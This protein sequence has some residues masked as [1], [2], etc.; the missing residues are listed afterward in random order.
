M[1]VVHGDVESS[2]MRFEPVSNLVPRMRLWVAHSN[3]YSFVISQELELGDPEWSGYTAS[4]KAQKADMRPFGKQPSN[5]IDGGPW[6]TFAQAEYACERTL[7]QLRS[8][9]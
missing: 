3:G 6:P 9:Q 4:W 7:K 8:K 1:A 5:R 2:V